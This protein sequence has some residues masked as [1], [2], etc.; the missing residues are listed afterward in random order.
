M[1]SS[2]RR[3]GFCCG[4]VMASLGRFLATQWSGVFQVI[5]ESSARRGR[6]VTDPSPIRRR[7]VVVSVSSRGLVV[8]LSGSSRE[9]VVV[10][11]QMRRDRVMVESSRGRD[12]VGVDSGWSRVWSLSR[13]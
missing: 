13:R 4:H 8:D 6:S 11:S 12:K 5:V 9:C 7:C 10:E 3:I 1:P 2:R